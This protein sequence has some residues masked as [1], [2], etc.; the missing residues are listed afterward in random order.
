MDLYL[1]DF[2]KTLYGYNFLKRLPALA[3]SGRV[4][5]YDLASTWWAGGYE[6]RAEAGEWPD[7]ASYL[8]M[9][10]EVTGARITM[11]QW[12]DARLAAMTAIP[13]SIAAL[14]RASTLGTVSLFSNNPS[15]FAESLPRL[16]PEVAEILGPNRITSCLL[17]AR[18]PM[19]A[20]YHRILEHFGADAESTF[21][22]DDSAANI[23]TAIE[24]GFHAHHF[25]G[26]EPEATAALDAA[27]TAFSQRNAAQRN[28]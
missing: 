28:P 26:P 23:A 4:S 9:F 1:F 5:Q 20:A 11:T 24:L 22:A 12:Q 19:P 6:A 8:E 2:D 15:I 25:T 27:I 16:A 14:R 7:A 21:F 17:R 18:K 13:G 10:E 3:I